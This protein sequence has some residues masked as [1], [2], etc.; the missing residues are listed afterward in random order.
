MLIFIQ[1]YWLMLKKHHFTENHRKIFIKLF[2]QKKK[3]FEIEIILKTKNF[4][5]FVFEWCDVNV[6]MMIKSNKSF[7]NFCIIE[8]IHA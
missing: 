3:E 6:E 5:S 1:I 8:L 2:L 4:Y 7:F